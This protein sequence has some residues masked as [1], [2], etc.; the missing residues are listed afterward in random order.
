MT[1]GKETDEK[2]ALRFLAN[3]SDSSRK[4]FLRKHFKQKPPVNLS[5]SKRRSIEW[6]RSIEMYVRSIAINT[7][8][9]SL[10]YKPPS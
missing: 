7:P 6:R 3:L 2:I 1:I 8:E 4:A 9:K 5:E 10:L